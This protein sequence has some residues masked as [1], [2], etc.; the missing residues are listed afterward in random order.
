MKIFLSGGTGLLGQELGKYLRFLAPTHKQ[1]DITKGITIQH[2][3]LVIHCAAYTDVERAEE[4]RIEC[5]Q[6]NVWGTLNMLEN[7]RKTPFVY[8]SSEYA[9]KPVNFYALTKSLAEQLVFT[10]PNHLIIRTLF[11]PK[12]WKYPKAF[13]D[14]YTQGDYVDKIAPLIAQTIL[15]WDKK[16]KMIYVGTGRKTIYDLARQ[17]RDVEPMSIK[18]VKVKIP[19]D[20]L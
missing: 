8:I 2:Y 13:V 4:E 9:H 7:F 10:H 17:T 6:T 11:K 16:S 1:F 12:P 20:Y 3:D 15:E 5:F 19:C 18:D 14:A